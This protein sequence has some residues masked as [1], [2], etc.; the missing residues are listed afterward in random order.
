MKKR[1]KNDD[2]GISQWI[3]LKLD[4]HKKGGNK[5]AMLINMTASIFSLDFVVRMKMV[6][7][8]HNASF[9]V[10]FSNDAMKP[11]RLKRHQYSKHSNLISK[12]REFFERMSDNLGSS[13][14]QLLNLTSVTLCALHTLFKVA[15]HI[16]KA[17]KPYTV[18]ETLIIGCI[19]DECQEMLGEIAAQKVSQLPM[20]NETIAHHIHNLAEDMED[21]LIAQVKSSEYYFLQLDEFTD[22]ANKVILTVF[23]KYEYK[24]DLKE[25]YFF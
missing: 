4:N 15:L 14:K 18:G 16:A 17:M 3:Q 21:Q 11:L 24:G 6:W 9:V 23:E 8:T 19:K 7:K 10:I 20:S 22:I 2:K 12:P 1:P 13:Q 25:E 5:L